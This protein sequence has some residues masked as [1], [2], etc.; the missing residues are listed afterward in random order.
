MFGLNT[1]ARKL[2]LMLV[3]SAAVVSLGVGVGSYL[4][5]SQVVSQLTQNNLSALAYERAK[6]V[7]DVIATVENDLAT[8]ANSQATNQAIR[9]FGNAWLQIQ[10]DKAAVLRQA[11]ITDN[12]NAAD[13][14]MLLDE[15]PAGNNYS[16]SHLKYNPG[17]RQQLLTRGYDDIYL[18]GADGNIYYSVTKSDDYAGNVKDEASPLTATGLGK[19]FAAAT[20]QTEPGGPVVFADFSPYP[21]DGSMSAFVGQPIFNQANGRMTGI[22]AFRFGAELLAHVTGDRTGLGETGEVLVVGPDKLLRVDSVFDEENNV[23]AT[24]IDA[25]VIDTALGGTADR[26]FMS[27]YRGTQMLVAAAPVDGSRAS[28]AV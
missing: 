27:S 8:T 23:L 2:P 17:Y 21:V 16:P 19:L 9:D 25:P 4:I 28:A 14:R 11:F 12:P 13:Q 6:Q 15:G 7:A 5:G 20:A 24:T 18:I 10:G 22:I 1:I 3:A 26:G